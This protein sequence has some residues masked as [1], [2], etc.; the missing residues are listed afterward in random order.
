MF[1]IE[2]ILS[3]A[4]KYTR[5]GGVKITVTQNKVLQIADTGIGIAPEDVPR[6]FEKGFT[7]YNGRADKK[8]TGLGLY[9][10]SLTADRLS[11]RITVESTV[12]KGTVFSLDLHRNALEVE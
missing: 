9:L 10:C 8:S 6:I 12:G 11:H 7:G 3:N 1:I 4:V 5:K 2:Q